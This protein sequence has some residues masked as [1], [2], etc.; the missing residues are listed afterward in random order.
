MLTFCS[1]PK[2]SQRKTFVADLAGIDKFL[3]EYHA[4]I[5]NE[6]L[7]IV[8]PVKQGIVVAHQAIAFNIALVVVGVPDLKL[9]SLKSAIGKLDTM[10][11]VVVLL[12]SNLS[13]LKFLARIPPSLIPKYEILPP[14]FTVSFGLTTRC[15]AAPE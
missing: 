11:V 1:A 2:M 8:L 4:L 9:A 13:W 14:A 15:R 5:L 6:K 12:D 7:T 3:S 10:P